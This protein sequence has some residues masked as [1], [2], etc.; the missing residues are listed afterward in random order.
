MSDLRILCLVEVR[1]VC[2]P[3][4]PRLAILFQDYWGSSQHFYVAVFVFVEL[5][6]SEGFCQVIN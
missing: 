5:G 6:E 1:G 3:G 4:Q 2:V